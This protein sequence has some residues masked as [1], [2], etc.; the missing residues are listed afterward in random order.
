MDMTADYLRLLDLRTGRVIRQVDLKLE[1]G[2]GPYWACSWDQA[3]D[4][5]HGGRYLYRVGL[6]RNAS[7]AH[8][9]R[10]NLDSGDREAKTSPLPPATRGGSALGKTLQRMAAGI[11][12]SRE[13]WASGFGPPWSREKILSPDGRFVFTSYDNASE[14]QGGVLVFDTRTLAL[15]AHILP[16]ER[17]G[18]EYYMPS[19]DGRR[20]YIL[21]G[22]HLQGGRLQGGRLVVTDAFTGQVLK[23]LSPS[24]DV[25]LWGPAAVGRE[26][27]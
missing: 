5:G 16:G 17:V 8:L 9:L 3:L 19:A 12:S 10:V 21:Q 2:D 13:A 20:L 26:V 23:E 6:E 7:L 22:A 4:L 25:Y 18:R 1:C 11:F 27:R 15:L 14:T 24:L